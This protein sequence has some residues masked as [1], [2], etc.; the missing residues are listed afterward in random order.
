M[1]KSRLFYPDKTFILQ[2]TQ[3]LDGLSRRKRLV[4]IHHDAQPSAGRALHRPDDFQI[5][6]P[7]GISDLCLNGRYA[8]TDP[9]LRCSC[10]ISHSV[11]ADRAVNRYRSLDTPKQPN[12]RETTTASERVPNR[13]VDS[14]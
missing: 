14:G 11:K 1:R 9:V 7:G 10:G 6:A 3:T 2:R 5:L 13:H 8:A 12:Q 4:V